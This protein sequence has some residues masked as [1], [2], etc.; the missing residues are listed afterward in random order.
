VHEKGSGLSTG[1]IS[2]NI[3]GSFF[4]ETFTPSNF[5][6]LCG[7]YFIKIPSSQDKKKTASD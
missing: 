6:I 4:L 7:K 5:S 3:I 2:K 1:T